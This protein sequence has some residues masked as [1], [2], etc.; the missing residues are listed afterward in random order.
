MAERRKVGAKALLVGSS[1]SALPI[2]IYLKSQGLHV[3]VCGNLK[4]DSCVSWADE[5]FELDYSQP[6]LVLDLFRERKFDFI[7]PS[8]NDAAIETASIVA[9]EYN[10]PGF[11]SPKTLTKIQ[12]K[13]EFRS[14]CQKL[15]LNIPNYAYFDKAKSSLEKIREIGFPLLLKPTKQ[16]SGRGIYKITSDSELEVAIERNDLTDDY[17]AEEYLEGSLHSHSAFIHSGKIM[18]EF[19]ADEFCNAYMFQVDCSNSPSILPSGI[20]ERVSAQVSTLIESLKL[21]DGLLHTQFIVKEN[22]PYLIEA[23]RRCPGDL[24]PEMIKQSFGFNYIENYTN[25]F[26]DKSVGVSF[27]SESTKY[28]ARHTI[29]VKSEKPFVFV[30]LLLEN[31]IN[32]TFYPLKLSGEKLLS[33]PFDKAAILFLEFE[34]LV[35]LEEVTPKLNEFTVLSDNIE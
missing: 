32:Y 9:H 8:C 20:Q 7:V 22:K 12:N 26:I 34:S 17:L 24:F 28:I 35:E 14:I 11:D 19:F 18:N 27:T 23:M 15:E 30:R 1:F 5:Y 25:P 31:Y 16:F 4:S 6:E 29:S 2:L 21:V 13:N 10:L 3:T 33:A